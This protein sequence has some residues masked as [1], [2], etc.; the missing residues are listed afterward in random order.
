MARGERQSDGSEQERVRK[1]VALHP[2]TNA[3]LLKAVKE[4][5]VTEQHALSRMVELGLAVREAQ[6]EGK[7]VSIDGQLVKFIYK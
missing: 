2:D 6:E 3:K 4:D 1:S 5:H 7:P